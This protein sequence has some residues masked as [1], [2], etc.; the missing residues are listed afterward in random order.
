MQKSVNVWILLMLFDLSAHSVYYR[1]K[2]DHH[3][4]DDGPGGSDLDVVSP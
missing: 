1:K 3:A 4:N 2:I